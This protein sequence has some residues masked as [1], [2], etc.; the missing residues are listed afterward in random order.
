M[1]GAEP[2]TH[3]GG[4]LGALV[5]HG[6]GG[7]PD[8][9]KAWAQFLADAGLTVV[10][11]RLPGHGTR[12]QDLNA[13]VWQDWYLEA[14]RGLAGLQKRCRRTVVMG[15]ANGATLGLRLAQQQPEAVAGLVLVNPV[16]QSERAERRVL[17]YARRVLPAL[18]ALNNDIK[19]R[20]GT[21]ASYTRIPL[22][23]AYSMTL[24]WSLVKSDIHKVT[25]PLLLMRS[26]DDHL[27]EPSNAAWL[28][29]NVASRDA[30]EVLLED[31]YHVATVD[32]DAPLIF[33]Q[34]LEFAR[35]VTTDEQ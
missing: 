30:V 22:N 8:S 13:T 31:S 3:D 26:A 21:H 23:A 4:E 33:E 6:F 9:V 7:S 10:A 1:T 2:F 16:V 24:L 27:V 19:K 12:W 32:N 11:P 18:P 25:Q 17:P 28:L 15:L 20:G 29:A 34:S 14:H 5:L 35:R